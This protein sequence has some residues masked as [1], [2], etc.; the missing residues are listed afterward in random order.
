[1]NIKGPMGIRP[2]QLYQAQQNQTKQ[3][4]TNQKPP[5]DT[6]E[7]SPQAKNIKTLTTKTLALPDI[8]EEKVTAI[9][10][11]IDSGKYNIS[12]EQIAKSMLDNI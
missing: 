1:M 9:K 10:Q 3:I 7:I 12:A 11:Q 2:G 5:G 8:R 4:K 6:I